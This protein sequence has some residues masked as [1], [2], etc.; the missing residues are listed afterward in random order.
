MNM[1]AQITVG[2]STPT[3]LPDQPAPAMAFTPADEKRAVEAIEFTERYGDRLSW[4]PAPFSYVCWD[5]QL[6]EERIHT[7]CSGE[8][9]PI[10]EAMRQILWRREHR[11]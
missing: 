7:I 6:N 10:T 3:A 11:A 2:A 5:R 1:H 9:R 4:H 8:Y